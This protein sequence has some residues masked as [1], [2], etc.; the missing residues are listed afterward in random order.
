M[1]LEHAIEKLDK[2]YT[3]LSKGKAQKIKPDHLAKV[4][5]KLQ[6]KE[7]LLQSELAE[8]S[9]P[10][11]IDRLERKLALVREQKARAK[12]LQEQLDLA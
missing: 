1:G 12:W 11:K 8:A 9:K 7:D 3:R 4:A 2:Y 10:S 5:R 6:A